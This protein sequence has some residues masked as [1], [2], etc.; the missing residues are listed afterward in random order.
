MV[1][2]LWFK[3]DV[4]KLTKELISRKSIN[5]GGNE[6]EIFKYIKK[7]IDKNKFSYKENI[8]MKNNKVIYLNLVI[9][10]RIY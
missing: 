10:Y 7:L 2:R 8:F 3:L 5:P 1:A 4:T 9:F 6:I